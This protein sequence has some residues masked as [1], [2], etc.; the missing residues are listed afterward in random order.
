MP[1]VVEWMEPIVAYDRINGNITIKHLSTIEDL[2]ELFH[3]IGHSINHRS[4][5]EDNQADEEKREVS[6]REMLGR[7]L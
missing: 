3:E 4:E 2:T 7:K 6:S 5:D 1:P